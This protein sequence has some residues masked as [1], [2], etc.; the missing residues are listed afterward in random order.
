MI[1]IYIFLNVD[2]W[3]CDCSF[4]FFLHYCHKTYL[5]KKGNNTDAIHYFMDDS[6]FWL[7]SCLFYLQ[8][9]QLD[10]K[11]HPGFQVGIKIKNFK[12]KIKKKNDKSIQFKCKC[13]IKVH[14]SVSWNIYSK[15]IYYTH[16][17]IS[18]TDQLIKY[19]IWLFIEFQLQKNI[20][21][22]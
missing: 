10:N 12:M 16:N 1:F 5:F 19:I 17:R 18:T 20:M 13:I 14:E 7:I 15:K 2:D 21:I 3:F 6:I 22:S 9:C 8:L 4:Y 11:T